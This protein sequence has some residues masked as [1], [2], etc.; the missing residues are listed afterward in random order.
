MKLLKCEVERR[1]G[2]E[3]FREDDP[4]HPERLCDHDILIWREGKGF[5]PNRTETSGSYIQEY[6]RQN[7][8]SGF[9]RDC[10]TRNKDYK[11]AHEFVLRTT[12]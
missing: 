1:Y 4:I 3:C 2:G 9:T 5:H 8:I 10:G 6:V 7:D 11:L 12:V